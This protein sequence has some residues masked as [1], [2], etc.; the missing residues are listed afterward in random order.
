MARREFNERAIMTNVHTI[1]EYRVLGV[2][3][4]SKYFENDFSCT[5]RQNQIESNKCE[6]W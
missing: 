5:N 6:I 4:N 1:S 2:V 3:Q